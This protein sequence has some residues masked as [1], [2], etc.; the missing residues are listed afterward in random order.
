LISESTSDFGEYLIDRLAVSEHPTERIIDPLQDLQYGF[1]R[2]A[3]LHLVVATF[4]EPS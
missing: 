3:L 1:L 2:P 4:R